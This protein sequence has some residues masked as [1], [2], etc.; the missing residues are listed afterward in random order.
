MSEDELEYFV[1]YITSIYMPI[2]L[3]RYFNR[4]TD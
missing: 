2:F 3:L 4:L 1:D